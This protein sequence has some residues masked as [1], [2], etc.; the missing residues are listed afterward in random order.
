MKI[1][2]D[3]LQILDAIDTFGSYAAAS[4]ALHRVPSA[5]TH[6]MQKL[7]TD[8]GVALFARQGRR[9]VLTPA[10]RALLDDG[11]HLLRAAA[12]LECRVRRVATG[13]ETRLTIAVEGLIPVERLY[14]LLDRFYAA[15]TGTEVRLTREVLGGCWDALVTERADLAIGAPGDL[16][17]GVG[18]ATRPLGVARMVFAVAPGH[19]LAALPEPIPADV[20]QRYRAVAVADTSRQLTARSSGLLAGQDVLTVPDIVAKAEAQAAGLGVGSLPLGLAREWVAAGRLVIREVEAAKPESP[21]FIAWRGKHPGR[22]L[23]WF[24]DALADEATRTGLLADLA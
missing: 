10:G 18:L 2:L 15:G 11:R 17:A 4:Q 22:G 1:T 14:P 19:P 24:L 3:A 5:L 16:P 21:L 13:W 6:A 23:A 7:E 20:V 8:L 9:A 12:D